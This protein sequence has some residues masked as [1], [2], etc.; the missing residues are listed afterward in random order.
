MNLGTL[1]LGSL[2]GLTIGLLAV[3]LV[4]IYKS[5][6]FLNL[7]N[8]Q[9]GAVSAL[10]LAKFVIDWGWS[11]WV[12]FPVAVVVGLGTGLLVERLFIRPLRRKGASSVRLMLGSLA[13]SQVLLALIFI[14]ALGP[15]AG[16]AELYPQPFVSH[17]RVG[18]VVL[19]GMS[20]LTALLV[21]LLVA[22]LAVFMRY[23]S[24]GRQ[25][26]A[27]ANNP[28][29]ARLCGISV[30]KV[31]A[32][33]WGLAGALS[34][35]SA[36]L[37][38]PTQSSFDAA[39]LGPYIL[40]LTL[41]AAAF[42]AFVSL[43]AALGGGV[44][45]GLILQCV[46]SQTSDGSTGELA[47]FVA[48]LLVVL[49]RG[50]RIGKV[51]YT[52]G[53][54]TDAPS[55]VRVP[56][57]LS[58]SSLVRYQRT[59]LSLA[60]LLVAVLL[61]HLPYFRTEANQFLLVLILLYALVA[62]GLTMLMG[63]SGQISLGHFAI[64]GLAAYLAAR[65]SADHWSLAAIGLVAG[66]MGAAVMIVIGLPALRVG[67]L[68]LAVT[69]LGFAVVAG[70]WLFHQSWAGSSAPFVSLVPIHLG[71]DL[72][73][74]NSEDSIY[75]V[76]LVLL[77]LAAWSAGAMRRLGPGR[78]AIAVRDNERAASTYG[79]LPASTKL[80]I[81]GVSGLFAGVA[82]VLWGASWRVVSAAQFPPEV[83]V[84]L[85]ALP[86]IGGLGSISGAVAAA[87]AL[88]SVT[89]FIGPHV[90]FVFGSF[91]QNLGFQLFVAGILQLIVLLAYPTGIAGAVRTRWQRF[92]N[93]RAI[94]IVERE[95]R[96]PSPPTSTNELTSESN[97]E[98]DTSQ[99][100]A[101]QGEVSKLK[102]T[103]G[104]LAPAADSVNVD[105]AGH[106][107]RFDL[108]RHVGW[109][110]DE[111]WP[112]LATDDV[113]RHFGGIVA[114][115]GVKIEVRAGEIVG[116][117]GPNGAG[118]TTLMNVISGF[119]RPDSGSIKIFGQETS[120]LPP[121]F[122]AALGVARSFQDATL[123]RGLSVVETIQVALA[124]RHKVGAVGAMVAAPWV[125]ATEVQTRIQ[126]ERIVERF[127]LSPWAD[128]LTSDLSTG[129]RRICDLAAQVA[130]RPRLL[131]LDEPTAGVA[132][133]ES[134]VFGPLLRQIR[135]ELS[136]AVLII[137][138]DMPLL[139]GLCDRVYAMEAGK[140]IATGSPTQI[141]ENPAVIRSYLGVEESAISRS[142]PLDVARTG[143]A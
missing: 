116:L 106:R 85:I 42:G 76:A 77:A 87:V 15:N 37:V 67:G 107:L 92:L 130:T 52:S 100:G 59:W 14:P 94:Q 98:S 35:V 19:N 72:G 134:E 132:Q 33:T 50:K 39:A 82:G 113:R 21:P 20:L 138:H 49:V 111:A 36:V 68:T 125:Q 123:F 121:D 137:E 16:Q 29:A 61:P 73:T 48:I 53:G 24:L 45:L 95:R 41:G 28:E 38:A 110:V 25:I 58:N 66:L 88:Y 46:T 17:V 112:P 5:N 108:A 99:I 103:G 18:G 114:L 75:Y 143:P 43:P 56:A 34:A 4:L 126:A 89:F 115:D 139:M 109:G 96:V 142:G 62:I 22:A 57:A 83:S 135:Q 140:V 26:R 3:G 51:F 8:A 10:L 81:L 101:E 44:V 136:C 64:V 32:I 117:I 119:E 13:V 105:T 131:L 63:W 70:D 127:G 65:L 84:A 12:A 129:T 31:S 23:S 86:V 128:V 60:S 120:D 118:K 133:R 7:A 141:R 91:G 6:R 93:R 69:T 40:M 104:A 55:P 47:V 78:N 124:Y 90:T 79:L 54:V 1:I 9:V 11:W 71:P 97:G 74:P 27:A 80:T 122:R 2:N 30:N 102:F